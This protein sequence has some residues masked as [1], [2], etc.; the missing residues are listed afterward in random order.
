MGAS[1]FVQGSLLASWSGALLNNVQLCA[2]HGNLISVVVPAW[3]CR[4]SLI[5]L[6]LC[7]LHDNFSYACWVCCKIF[8]AG[9]DS[10][11]QMEGVTG[12][13]WVGWRW[14]TGWGGAARAFGQSHQLQILVR[15]LALGAS[16]HCHFECDVL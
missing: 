4:L 3:F 9:N 8:A 16:H 7:H 5:Q 11:L 10:I 14:V 2:S 6:L 1:A 15:V 13:E 12:A